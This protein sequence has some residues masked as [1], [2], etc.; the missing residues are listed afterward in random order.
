MVLPTALDVEITL[1]FSR[2]QRTRR[3]SRTSRPRF[4]SEYW[5]TARWQT[6]LITS[7]LVF[8]KKSVLAGKVMG[9]GLPA[10]ASLGTSRDT[11]QAFSPGE[12]RIC[13]AFDQLSPCSSPLAL[14][15]DDSRAALLRAGCC[16]CAAAQLLANGFALAWSSFAFSWSALLSFVRGIVTRLPSSRC[17][18]TLPSDS[19]TNFALTLCVPVASVQVRILRRCDADRRRAKPCNR[20]HDGHSTQYRPKRVGSWKHHAHCP[21]V[22]VVESRIVRRLNV[23]VFLAKRVAIA[24]GIAADNDGACLQ[25]MR[26]TLYWEH[27]LDRVTWFSLAGRR[28]SEPCRFRSSLARVWAPI[29]SPVYRDR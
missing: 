28:R 18:V 26:W 9:L 2:S 1:P 3:R 6:G 24:L 11:F 13:F 14:D 10:G 29:L 19:S 8:S 7:A 4:S 22:R 25:S 12:G 21:P 23:I 20:N 17:K 5:T 16:S 27:P 15:L